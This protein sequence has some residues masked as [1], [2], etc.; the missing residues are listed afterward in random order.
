MGTPNFA[1]PSLEALVRSKHEVVGIFTQPDRP[2]GRGKI[3][4]QSP[5]KKFALAEAIPVYQPTTLKNH[6][7][8]DTIKSYNPDIII[9][10]AYGQLLPKNI[11]NFSRYRSVN[12]HASLLP[13]YRGAAPINWAIIR[14]EME[15]GITTMLM[16]EKLDA[17]DILLQ[18]KIRISPEDHV[19]TLH[20]K[21]AILGAQKIIETI[22]GL[23][24]GGITPIKQN[25]DQATYAP[26]LKKEDG[27]I[28][29]ENSA[30][31][32]YNLIRGTYN[33]PGSYTFFHNKRLKILK[34]VLPN[35][36]KSGKPASI[37]KVT[38]NGIEVAAK[39]GSLI[40]TSVQP[41]G[42]PEMGAYQFTLGKQINPGEH[43]DSACEVD[44]AK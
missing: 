15:T 21:L 11:L 37:L 16:T 1:K 38:K 2:K 20:D 32:I 23:E 18:E 34:A 41:E 35:R 10:V 40:I 44:T 9:V 36:T 26:K 8:F 22:D 27:L 14:G 7:V 29:W 33:W 42:K 13:K 5:I 4:S 17:G 6:D 31:D 43:F 24:S 28:N 39:D 19:M 3:L 25:H 12:L 30:I